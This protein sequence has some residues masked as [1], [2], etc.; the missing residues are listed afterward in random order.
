M[1]LAFSLLEE[2]SSLLR[3]ALIAAMISLVIAVAAIW[4]AIDAS[5]LWQLRSVPLRE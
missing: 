1:L 2:D 3:I 4:E 5:A